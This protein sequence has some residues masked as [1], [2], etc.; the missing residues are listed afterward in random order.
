MSNLYKRLELLANIA[1]IVVALLLCGVLVKRYLLPAQPGPETPEAARVKPGTKLS[2]PGLD[3]SKSEKT[4]LLV[5]STDC[6]YCTE[7]APFYHRLAEQRAGR[8]DVRLIAVL[9]QGVGE[10]QQYLGQL[11]I[12]VDEVTQAAP[13]AFYARATPTLIVVDKTGSVVESW[14]GKL[15]AEQEA[16]VVRHFLGERPGI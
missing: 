10:A 9:P 15:P 11:N 8:Q 14:V 3:W 12:R 6:R 5:L 16:E 4:L 7:S 2:S 13:G 1:I